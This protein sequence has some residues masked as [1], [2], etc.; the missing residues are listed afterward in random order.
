MTETGGLVGSE[1][2]SPLQARLLLGETIAAAAEHPKITKGVCV[3][4][5]AK[6]PNLPL[7]LGC[8]G[9]FTEVNHRIALAKAR[10]VL[11]TGRSTHEQASHMARDGSTREDY[12]GAVETLFGGGVLVVNDRDEIV[13]AVAY[14]G[15]D[16]EDD[17]K[18][19]ATA[20]AEVGLKVGHR[21]D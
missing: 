11:A 9:E 8:M 2:I 6:K 1:S 12:G 13:G 21:I 5:G 3:V 4:I 18:V 14:S 15:G 20:I 10:T 19:C 16:Q 17:I 7:A